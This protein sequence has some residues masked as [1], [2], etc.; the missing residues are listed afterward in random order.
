MSLALL[1]ITLTVPGTPV[2][3]DPGARVTALAEARYRIEQQIESRVDLTAFGQGEQ[4]QAQT[5]VWFTTVRYADTTGG[6]VLDAVLDSVQADLGL[7]Q[8]PPGAMDSARGTVF[9]GVLDRWGRVT[10]LT[11]TRAGMLPSLFEAQLK[12]FHPRVKPDARPGEAWTDTLTVTT[13]TPQGEL[14]TTTVSTFTH[15]GTTQYEGGPSTEVQASFTTSVRGSLETPGG[16]A[17]LEGNGTGT[18]TY[19]L[20]TDGLLRGAS[21]TATGNGAIVTG[22]APAPIPLATTT[23]V[24]VSRIP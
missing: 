9:H 2:P 16:P 22:F 1:F 11:G 20:G 4:V 17:D 19:H 13:N 14:S 24:T 23:T 15:G 18:A 21:S 5:F 6:R 7:A 8:L 10:T 3:A 12:T